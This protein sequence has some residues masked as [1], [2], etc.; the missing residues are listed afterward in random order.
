MT[1]KSALVMIGIFMAGIRRGI[2]MLAYCPG[3]ALARILPRALFTVLV[4]LAGGLAE[5]RAGMSRSLL[6]FSERR[7]RV[8]S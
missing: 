1:R 6:I 7:L 5:T 8:R 2:P 4:L 3:L